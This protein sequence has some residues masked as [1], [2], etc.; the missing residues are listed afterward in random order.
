MGALPAPA[1]APSPSIDLSSA[2]EGITEWAARVGAKV[3]GTYALGSLRTVFADY[4]NDDVTVCD[5]VVWG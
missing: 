1:N 4:D 2:G 3:V 5:W